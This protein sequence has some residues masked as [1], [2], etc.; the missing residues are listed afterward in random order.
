M[1]GTGGIHV[2]YGLRRGM[3]VQMRRLLGLLMML[4]LMDEFHRCRMWLRIFD[5]FFD[6]GW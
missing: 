3:M 6:A 4:W 5:D 1:G 2:V